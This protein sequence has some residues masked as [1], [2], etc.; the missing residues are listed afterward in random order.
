MTPQGVS[1][2]TGGAGFI[3]TNLANRLMSQG[4]RVLVFDDLSRPGVEQNLDWL[5]E[6]YP[7]QLSVELGDVCD[8]EAVTQAVSQGAEI[9][10]LA[11][12]VAVTSSLVDPVYD[13]NVN[14]RGTLNVLE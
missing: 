5:A 4:R 11:A 12:Q 8:I 13:F 1:L 2:I 14:A 7:D 10:H 6:R 3:G 9:Y